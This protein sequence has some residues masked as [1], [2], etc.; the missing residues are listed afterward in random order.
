M[1]HIQSTGKSA[2][3][4]FNDLSIERLNTHYSL[5]LRAAASTLPVRK[6][7]QRTFQLQHTPYK[8]THTHTHTHTC[9]KNNY[10]ADDANC[11][12]GYPRPLCPAT[13]VEATSCITQWRDNAMLVAHNPSLLL[14]QPCN[15]SVHAF[16]EFSRFN[17]D[18][19]IFR[20]KQ[21]QLQAY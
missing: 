7:L 21:Q 6:T 2:T 13:R 10:A 11:R 4:Q 8:S 17:R 18:L 14:A 9:A 3:L 19:Q 5:L 1:V 20:E 12:M 15:H 16:A